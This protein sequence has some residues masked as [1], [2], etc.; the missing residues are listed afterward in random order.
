VADLWPP[1]QPGSRARLSSPQIATIER[2]GDTHDAPAGELLFA[3]GDETYDLIVLL[4]GNAD[5]VQGQGGPDERVINSYGPGEFLG[6]VGLLTGQRVFLSAVMTQSGRVIRVASA[7]VHTIMSQEPDLSEVILRAFL[8]RHTRLTEAGTGLTL[9]GSR[10]DPD[11]R[12]LLGTLARNR[13]SSRWLELEAADD[14]EQMLSGLDVPEDELPIVLVPGR[15]ILRNPSNARL[16]ET[17]GLSEPPTASTDETCDLLVIGAGPAGLAAAV[18]GA[19]EGLDT[20]LA[21]SVAPGGQAGT[22][23]RIENLLGFPAGV[24]GDEL[25]TRA[26]LQARKFGVHFKQSCGASALRRAGA[27]HQVQFENGETI[28]AKAVVV[29]TGL[30]HNRLAVDR[31]AEFEGVGVYYAATAIE[32]I[33]CSGQPAVIVGAGNSAGQAALFLSRRCSKVTIAMR[34]AALES[35][36]SRYLIDEIKTRSTIDVIAHMEVKRLL[37]EHQLTGVELIDNRDGQCVAHD[38]AGLF[39]FTGAVPST[40]WLNGEL[41]LDDHGFLLTG[42]DVPPGRRA[43]SGED[44]LVLETSR[45][46]VFAV[47]DVRS[48]SVKRAATAI[49]EGSMAVRLVFER[50]QQNGEEI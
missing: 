38:A 37:G 20:T 13:V 3:D 35:S 25:A 44:L 7:D 27:A 36:M 19:S 26:M 17:L 24:T 49:G 39:I 48:Q 46:G 42:R 21:E 16:L 12:R 8:A 15:P 32:A 45:P 43:E 5:I 47:G 18:Y 28:T 41:D 14:I 6:E 10:F 2:Y 4:T 34:G 29:A 23:S 22:S 50:L 9:V 31:L 11:T 1:E 30:R 40:G 33:A